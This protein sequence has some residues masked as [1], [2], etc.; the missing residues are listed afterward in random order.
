MC[1]CNEPLDLSK[2]S[3][4]ITYD[5]LPDAAAH[6]LQQAPGDLISLLGTKLV[7]CVS[8]LNLTTCIHDLSG[9]YVVVG[10]SPGERVLICTPPSSPSLRC[11]SLPTAILLELLPFN[12]SCTF[13]ADNKAKSDLTVGL[14]TQEFLVPPAPPPARASRSRSSADDDDSSGSDDSAIVRAKQAVAARVAKDNQ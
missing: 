2:K 12:H 10:T 14:T 8:R 7:A 13:E 6:N 9:T 5:V 11:H 4:R 1:S 3:S